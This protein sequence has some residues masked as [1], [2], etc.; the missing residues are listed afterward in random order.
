MDKFI[1]KLLETH[2][3]NII[4]QRRDELILA[5]ETCKQNERNL[6]KLEKR[7]LSLNLATADRILI[8]DYIT[9]IQKADHRNADLSYIAGVRDTV[10]LLQSLNL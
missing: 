6:S 5:D 10:K 3:G 8:N 2:L 7:Y 4:D 1:N 9:S